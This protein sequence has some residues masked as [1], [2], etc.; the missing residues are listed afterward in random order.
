MAYAA[1]LLLG[2]SV[3]RDMQARMLP[4]LTAALKALWPRDPANG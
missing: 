1:A 3:A 4:G 2:A